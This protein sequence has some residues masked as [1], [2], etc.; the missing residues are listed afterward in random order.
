MQTDTCISRV[1]SFSNYDKS[2][3]IVQP[4]CHSATNDGNCPA[5]PECGKR[6]ELPVINE[7]PKRMKRATKVEVQIQNPRKRAGRKHPLTTRKK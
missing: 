6:K 2:D 1:L 7:Q 4:D 5:S 3:I